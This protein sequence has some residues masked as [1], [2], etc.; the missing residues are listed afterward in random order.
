MRRMPKLFFLVI[1]ITGVIN[2]KGMWPVFAK[3]SCGSH[4]DCNLGQVCCKGV[5]KPWRLQDN[6][7]RDEFH[8]RNGAQNSLSCVGFYCERLNDCGSLSGTR[9]L[10]CVENKC[11]PCQRGRPK[12]CTSSS[13]CPSGHCCE[14]N[15]VCSDSGCKKTKE[16]DILDRLPPGKIVIF[17]GFLAAMLVGAA[18]CCFFQ[19]M[20]Q[21]QSGQNIVVHAAFSGSSRETQQK[22]HNEMPPEN[23]EQHVLLF[24]NIPSHP[25]SSHDDVDYSPNVPP[26]LYSFGDEI[27]SPDL[28]DDPP[29]RCRATQTACSDGSRER[30]QNVHIEMQLE[31]D[32]QHILLSPNIPSHPSTSPGDVDY[33]P[34][35]PS[36]DLSVSPDRNDVSPP[37]YRVTQV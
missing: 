1:L 25:S 20:R 11:L 24:P 29:P 19:R 21:R 18:V 35:A 16:D 27:V 26:P 32:E 28:T 8:C 10:C 5:L 17:F 12:A 15:N 36:P 22:I 33:I 30:Q 13:D 37:R 31:N 4:S 7:S 3:D 9:S 2:Y 6:S 34:D 14:T 23:D